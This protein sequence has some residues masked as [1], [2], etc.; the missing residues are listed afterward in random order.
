MADRTSANAGSQTQMSSL[1]ST[2]SPRILKKSAPMGET[3]IGRQGA[4]K[5][6]LSKGASIATPNPPLVKESNIKCDA[7]ARM[8]KIAS[9]ARLRFMFANSSLSNAH[10]AMAQPASMA[11][12]SECVMPRCP[13]MLRYGM[14]NHNPITSKSGKTEHNAAQNRKLVGIGLVA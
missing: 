11:N 12:N 3:R 10:H 9:D 4:K 2:S 5:R 8:K 6:V 13:H 1:P 14:P 7:V